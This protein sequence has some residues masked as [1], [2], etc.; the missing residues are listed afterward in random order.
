MSKKSQPETEPSFEESL[1]QLQAIVRQLEDGTLGLDESMTQF[2]Q[3]VKLLRKCYAVLDHTEQRI[4][5]LTRLD[6]DG[7]PVLAPFDNTGT[8][9]TKEKSKAGRRKRA[10]KTEDEDSGLF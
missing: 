6:D 2:E 1:E 8:A 7:Q 10:S 3:G 9:D 4:E 5:L